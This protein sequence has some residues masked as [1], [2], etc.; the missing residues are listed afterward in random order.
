MRKKSLKKRSLFAA[1]LLMTSLVF[2]ANAAESKAFAA[3][4][5]EISVSTAD[6]L[7]F[8]TKSLQDGDVISIKDN[9]TLSRN[10]VLNKSV[11]V[12]LN[13][14]SLS[15]DNNGSLQCGYSSL[16]HQE[17]YKYHEGH[18]YEETSTINHSGY[19]YTDKDGKW[20]QPEYKDTIT[21][22][23]WHDPWTETKIEEIRKYHDEIKISIKNGSISHSAGKNGSICGS[24]GLP[25][26]S[27]LEVISGTTYLSDINIYGGKG[28]NGVNGHDGGHGGNVFYIEQGNVAFSNSSCHAFPGEGGEGGEKGGKKGSSGIIS[29]KMDHVFFLDNV[30][31]LPGQ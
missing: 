19:W 27:T 10:I 8:A 18:W 7:V 22:K 23:K 13:G 24:V 14:H 21:T 11:T 30:Y 17:T 12:D 9:I 4:S 1:M 28:G 26:R 25:P 31:F 29:E 20:W 15:I 2:T 5:R 16:D 6:E 3:E